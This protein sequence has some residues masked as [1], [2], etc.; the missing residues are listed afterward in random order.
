VKRPPKIAMLVVPPEPGRKSSHL[1]LIEHKG[2]GW[3][4]ARCM[5]RAKRCAA[6][7]CVHLQG[8]RW[9]GSNRPIK[10]RPREVTV[11]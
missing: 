6:G 7:E 10:P 1:V 11:A 8:I 9:S 2:G 3:Y 4:E 5:G